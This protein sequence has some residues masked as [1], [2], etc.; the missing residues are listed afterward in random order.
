M[1]LRRLQLV[2]IVTA[3][4]ALAVMAGLFSTEVRIGCLAVVVAAVL[5]TA[6]ERR[7]PG[8]GWWILLAAGAA[9]SVAG[10][11]VEEVSEPAET[12]AGLIA[13]AGAALVVVAAT[14]GFPV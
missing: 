6:P 9:L 4:A 14:V 12:I 3:I 5:V 1:S 8:G 7:R 13:I 11:V 10:L 2:L